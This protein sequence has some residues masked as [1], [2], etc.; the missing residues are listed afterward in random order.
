MSCEREPVH[1]WE[2]APGLDLLGSVL[3][4]CCLHKSIH[5]TTLCIVHG[6][7][8]AVKLTGISNEKRLFIVLVD[9]EFYC[10]VELDSSDRN[11]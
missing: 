11:A 6:L 2:L 5:N 10:I 9:H 3:A 4:L 8:N 7:I 1:V